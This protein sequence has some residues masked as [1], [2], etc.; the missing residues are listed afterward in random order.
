[1][2]ANIDLTENQEFFAR[3]ISNVNETFALSRFDQYFNERKFTS[4]IRYVHWQWLNLSK[5]TKP[6][7]DLGAS[8]FDSKAD[9]HFAMSSHCECCGKAIAPWKNGLCPKC[10]K[11]LEEY[12]TPLDEETRW[13]YQRPVMQS[14]KTIL[15]R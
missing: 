1:M 9:F 11:T 8:I 2:K 10:E 14:D 7:R 6:F 4:A 12:S 13:P 15:F 3:R 5:P